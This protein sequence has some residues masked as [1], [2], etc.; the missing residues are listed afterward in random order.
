[1]RAKSG[2]IGFLILVFSAGMALACP[3]LETATPKVGSTVESGVEN[4]SVKF[5]SAIAVA[6]SSLDVTD[7][8]GKKVNIGTAYSEA[9]TT[10]TTKVMPLSSG[11]YQVG[12]TI[13]CQHCEKPITGTYKFTVN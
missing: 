8:N 9:N 11:K 10:L 4:V 2:L 1:M 5:S 6:S 7:I 12:W 3:M 13:Q